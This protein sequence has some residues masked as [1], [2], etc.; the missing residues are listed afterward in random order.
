VR[1]VLSP[2]D[3]RRFGNTGGMPSWAEGD[4]VRV[5]AGSFEGFGGTI[6]QI[7]DVGA[8]VVVNVFGRGTPVRLALSDFATGRT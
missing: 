4:R 1:S 8:N 2:D 7:D 5:V 6:E 3:G